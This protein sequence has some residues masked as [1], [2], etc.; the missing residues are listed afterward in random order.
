MSEDNNHHGEIIIVRRGHD[1]HDDHHGGVWKIAFA[2]FMTA[3]MAFF[4]VMWL[5]NASDEKTKKAVANYF[6]PVKLMDSSTKPRGVDDPK[7]GNRAEIKDEISKTAQSETKISPDAV[8]EKAVFSDPYALLSAIAGSAGNA[9]APR[10][11]DEG[12]K[13]SGQDGNGISGGESFQDPFDPANWAKRLE[14]AHNPSSDDSKTDKQDEKAEP[15]DADT[16]LGE[17]AEA[18]KTQLQ[19]DGNSDEKLLYEVSLIE[20]GKA[21]KIALMEDTISAMFSVGSAKPTPKLIKAMEKIAGVLKKSTGEIAIIGHT[22]GRPFRSED[23]D[24]WRLSTA[25]AHMAYY[26][27]LRGGLADPR[28]KAIEGRAD[29]ELKFPKDKFAAGNRRIELIVRK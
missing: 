14:D 3:M 18:L 2:D 10:F 22:D 25:R 24:N 27:L 29:R 21:M 26:M 12:K 28:F 6:N 7:K 4:L 19:G 16:P 11:D 13:G 23:Y 20:G 8:D 15:I 1:D 5:I 9:E 17:V